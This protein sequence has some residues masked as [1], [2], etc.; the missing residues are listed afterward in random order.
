METL[1][2]RLAGAE[3]KAGVVGLQGD[4]GTGKTTLVRGW[5]RALGVTG[6]VRSPTYTLVEPYEMAQGRVYHFDL[7][8][9]S[10][11]EE[12]E[13]MGARDYFAR[14]SLCLIEW[15][16]RAM[17]WLAQVDLTIKIN[18]ATLGR[19]VSLVPHNA[20]GARFLDHFSSP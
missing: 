1:G 3:V 14:D 11:P 2:A 12:L 6:P 4:L 7:Y 13:Y 5:L 16:E 19:D 9:L 10:D 15:P 20:T 17:G 8:R 18:F